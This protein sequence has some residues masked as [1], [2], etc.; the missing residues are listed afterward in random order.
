VEELTRKTSLQ[1]SNPEIEVVFGCPIENE[2]WR[3]KYYCE[4]EKADWFKKN[5]YRLALPQSIEEKI[6][7]GGKVTE[8]EIARSASLF[9]NITIRNNGVNVMI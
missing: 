5:G 1:E 8:E 9:V 7:N 6:E 2:I 4:E 3:V